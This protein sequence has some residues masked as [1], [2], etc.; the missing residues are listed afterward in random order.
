[1]RPL[2]A[3]PAGWESLDAVGVLTIGDE[4][5]KFGVHGPPMGNQPASNK[6]SAMENQSEIGSEAASERG[7]SHAPGAFR[8]VFY[9]DAD[10]SRSWPESGTETI[11]KVGV[12]SKTASARC[13]E[14]EATLRNKFG[15]EGEME[16]VFEATGFITEVET[17][18]VEATQAW[19]CDKLMGGPSTEW[20]MCR[21][22]QLARVA[23]LL[24]L[25]IGAQRGDAKTLGGSGGAPE[26]SRPDLNVIRE[27]LPPGPSACKDH[28]PGGPLPLTR[29]RPWFH[30]VAK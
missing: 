27:P 12:T 10:V 24:A 14:N 22:R 9:I 13:L 18:A 11:C 23:L 5:S 19:S 17:H 15:I 16:V 21:P 7:S 30:P 29:P 6:Q 20:R 1:M 26:K 25:R 3:V 4:H 8:Q 28:P 2:K